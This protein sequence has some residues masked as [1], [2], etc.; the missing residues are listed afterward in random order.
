VS[1]ISGYVFVI[2][3][4]HVCVLCILFGMIAVSEIRAVGD[5]FFMLLLSYLLL[6]CCFGC[7]CFCVV[8]IVLKAVLV[9]VSLN[10]LAVV[11]YAQSMVLFHGICID[12]VT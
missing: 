8:L 5:S 4:L 6:L 12:S 1:C 3:L 10:I 2:F 11:I 7:R 9:S